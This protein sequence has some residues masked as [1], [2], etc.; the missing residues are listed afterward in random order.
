MESSKMA[1]SK[2]QKRLLP[3]MAGILIFLTVFFFIAS[4]IQLYYLHGRIEKYPELNLD[5]AFS[6]LKPSANATD[7]DKLN[8]AQWETLSILEKHALQRRYHQANVLLMSRIW[9]Q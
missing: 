6:M 7:V 2:W 3:L 1:I 4:F 8:Y 9:T 5:T